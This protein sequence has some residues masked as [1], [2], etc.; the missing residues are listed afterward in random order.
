MENSKLTSASFLEILFDGRN[1]AYG[2]YL[3]RLNYEHR[4]TVALAMMIGAALVFCAI[5]LLIPHKITNDQPLL[6]VTP[7][8]IEPYKAPPK[9]EKKLPV[10]K[11]QSPAPTPKQAMKKLTIPNITPDKEVRTAE[12]PPKQTDRIRVGPVTQTGLNTTGE[13][14]VPPEMKGVGT[15][16]G[17][18]VMPGGHQASDYEGIFKSVQVE[19]RFPGGP[20][21]WRNYLERNLRRS[22][23]MDHGAA[24]G[25]Y[26]VVVSFIVSAEGQTSSIQVEQAPH[27]DYGIAD[28]AIR[29][30]QRS[31]RWNPA[32]Q[33]GHAVTYREKQKIIFVV[34]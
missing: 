12:L 33:N 24:A 7:V 27:P 4:L 1:K 31:G 23:P 3:L 18:D 21:A 17:N 20:E 34:E 11:Q 15:D 30:I 5:M 28:E 22:I 29:V 9:K 32:I 8:R 19:A 6:Q 13:L 14:V 16:D 2:A 10:Y 25:R 26:T